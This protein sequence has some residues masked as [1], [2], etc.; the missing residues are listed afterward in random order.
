MGT[1]RTFELSFSL[2]IRCAGFVFWVS[3]GTT[4][5]EKV[6]SGS[7]LILDHLEMEQH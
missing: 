2:S 6:G 5:K 4:V 3:D 7:E 1:D